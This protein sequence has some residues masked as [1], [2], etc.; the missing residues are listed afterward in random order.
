MKKRGRNPIDRNHMI[1]RNR[2]I[3]GLEKKGGG[4]DIWRNDE[5]KAG[6]DVDYYAAIYIYTHIYMANTRIPKAVKETT[7]EI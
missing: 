4:G 5:A 6:F 3:S 1:S 2:R 7:S